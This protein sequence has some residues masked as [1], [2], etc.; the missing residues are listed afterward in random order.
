MVI[1]TIIIFSAETPELGD[2]FSQSMSLKTEQIVGLASYK[3]LQKNNYIYNNPLVSGYISYLG[4]KLST[5]IMDGDRKYTYFVVRSEQVNAF[6]IPGGY[7]GLN[8]GLIN[9][10]S[11]EAQLAGVVAHEISHVKLRHSAEMIAN[12]SLNNIPMWAGIIAGI[13]AGNAEASMAALRLGIG[14]SSQ[15]SINL[16]RE[17]EIEADDYGIEI[18]TRSNYDLEEMSNFFKTMGNVSGEI[19]RELSYLSTHPM[20]ENRIS[21]IQNKAKLQNNPI[22]NSTEDYFF[23][24]IYR[25]GFKSP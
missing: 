15:M 2:P 22:Q 10:T 24:K 16:I 6:A 21:H 7:I 12:M 5:S 4:N 1:P 18:M 17:N 25:S 20:Y 9:L 23:V 19:Q 11:S 3:R 13:F 14:Q 8:A